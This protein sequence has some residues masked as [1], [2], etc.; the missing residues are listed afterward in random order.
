[1]KRLAL[2]LLPALVSSTRADEAVSYSQE[3]RAV[4]ARAGCNQGTCHGNLNGKGGFK[5]SLRGENPAFDHSVM[6][7]EAG[8][9]RINALEP[10]ASLLLLKATGRVPHEGGVRFPYGSP[11]Y[12]LVRRWIAAGVASDIGKRPALDRLEVTPREAYLV[13]PTR[14]VKVQATARF[15]GGL[16]RD[17][18]GLAVFE[19]TNPKI[20]VSRS[21][22]VSA[23]E[24]GETTIVVRYLDRQQTVRLAFVADRPDFRWQGPAP[25]N[26]IDELVFAQL[27]KLRINPSETCT[28]AEFLRRAHLD[29]IGVLPTPD[30]TRRFVGDP[31]PDRRARL[32]ESLL[33][34]PEYADWWA[35]KWSDL[36]RVEEKQLDKKGVKVFHDWIRDSLAANKPLNRF[37]RELLASRGSTYQEPA[38]NY[39]RALRDPNTRGE[40]MAQ[41]FLGVRM[42]CAKCHNHPFNQWT[43][44]DY[45]QLSAFFARVQYKII[46]NTRRDKLDKH[47]FNGEQIVYQDEASEIKHPV[48][49]ETLT[50]AFLGAATPKFGQKDDRLL[51]L[52][53]WVADP[54][55]AFFARTQANRI[56]A[57]LLGRGLVEPIDDFRTTNP[58]AN[59]LLLAALAADLAAHDF[60]MKRLI[61]TI[62]SSRTYQLSDRPNATNADDETHYS[63]AL[64]RSLPAEALL[65]AVAQVTGTPLTFPGQADGLRA[66]QLPSFPSIR[67]GES[68]QGPVRFLKVFG[69][70]ERLLSCD[71]ERSDSTTLAQALT[72]ITGELVNRSLTAPDNRLGRLLASQ[73]PSP[74]IVEELYLA[75]LCRVPTVAERDALVGRI[76]QAPDRRA[77]LED[78]LWAL[79]NSKEF[80]LRK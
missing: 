25:V 11:E 37:A 44:N 10:D 2:L 49:G 60:D 21:G 74:A 19:S 17:V 58:P 53:D 69:K 68:F 4:F 48:T 73:T 56:W 64:V 77:A 26:Y 78:I 32:V 43:Q 31:S 28:D 20:N 62:V 52:A 30:E 9:R 35:L 46:D 75:S 6:T 51:A 79:L 54:K 41:V 29:L 34:R 15:A 3:V 24:P 27:K 65:D 66:A 7:R 22:E 71:C 42:Q 1:M 13:P 5:L 45:H 36:L 14:E 63:H 50:P 23:D 70:P 61:R 39:Y 57:N 47:E 12:D 67:R 76:E 33:A 55:N 38:A 80:L 40:A 59:E 72:L 18:S 8:G 16:R